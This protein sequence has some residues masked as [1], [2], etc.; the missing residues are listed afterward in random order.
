[1]PNYNLNDNTNHS[2]LGKQEASGCHV[3]LR[4][5][6]KRLCQPL[7]HRVFVCSHCFAL[8]F[9]AIIIPLSETKAPSFDPGTN[10]APT[11]VLRKCK[12]V[13]I[14]HMCIIQYG[15]LSHGATFSK[16]KRYFSSIFLFKCVVYI[17][18][19]LTEIYKIMLFIILFI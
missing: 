2:L 11:R 10:Q 13:C 17:S 12:F 16:L 18:P 4:L 8:T 19:H 15:N 9:Y 3:N 5:Q 6:G 7:P 14:F 1:M